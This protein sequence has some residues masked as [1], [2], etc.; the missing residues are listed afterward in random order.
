[1]TGFISIASYK[2]Y[3]QT[4]VEAIGMIPSHWSTFRFRDIFK[5][6]KGLN[7]T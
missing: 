2:V 4:Q 3:R 6:G 5:F 7:I 1:M